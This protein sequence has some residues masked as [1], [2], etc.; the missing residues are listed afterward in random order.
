MYH[1]NSEFAIASVLQPMKSS[2]RRPHPGR[3]H[4]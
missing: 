4:Q 3:A 2:I 1:D